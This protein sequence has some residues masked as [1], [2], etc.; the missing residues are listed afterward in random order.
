[1]AGALEWS[2]RT[3]LSLQFLAAATRRKKSRTGQRVRASWS[4]S[5][6]ASLNHTKPRQYR[7]TMA[8]PGTR[9]DVS[10]QSAVCRRLLLLLLT[11]LLLCLLRFLSFLSHL[12]LRNPKV[13]SM[14]VDLDMHH[15]KIHHN[16]KIDTARFEQGK[17]RSCRRV[18]CARANLSLT[19]HRRSTC[20]GLSPRARRSVLA[21]TG[22]S[23]SR[24]SA[25]HARSP[26]ALGRRSVRPRPGKSGRCSLGS[27]C[28]CRC[29][30]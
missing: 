30:A 14:Q 28:W 21:A 16:W 26:R 17:R 24:S 15:C 1:M 11:G 7:P 23:V 6:L 19:M 29:R 20:T 12:T 5:N 27:T 18:L 2:A 4:G 10:Q 25:N 3:E 13:G 22:G 8:K 9:L